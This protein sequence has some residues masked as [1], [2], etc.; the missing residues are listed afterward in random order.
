MLSFFFL[1]FK[2]FILTTCLT[3]DPQGHW[4]LLELLQ[5]HVVPSMSVCVS[6]P[7]PDLEVFLC[8]SSSFCYFALKMDAF[9]A[10]SGVQLLTMAN[11]A[12]TINVTEQVSCDLNDLIFAKQKIQSVGFLLRVRS[13]C[14]GWRCW[15]QL[16]RP[17]MA[18]SMS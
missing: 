7:P 6:C 12:L 18:V 3:F 17:K 1:F 5:H 11:Q 10:V 14:L 2:F 15:R 9:T 16:W 4:K 13:G 8:S